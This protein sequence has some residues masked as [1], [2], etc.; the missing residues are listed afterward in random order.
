MSLVLSEN[1]IYIIIYDYF[2][3]KKHIWYGCVFTIRSC[4][5]QLLMFMLKQ[6]TYA[7]F[8]AF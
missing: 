6:I 4:D 8:L 1:K 7:Y 3:K 5:V 2:T